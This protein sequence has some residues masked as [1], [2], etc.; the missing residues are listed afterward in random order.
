MVMEKRNIF[1]KVVSV[2][3]LLV[4]AFSLTMPVIAATS[5]TVSV[6]SSSGQKIYI[7]TGTGWTYSLGLKKTTV[8]VKNSGSYAFALYKNI[9]SNYMYVGELQPGQTKSYTAKGSGK[10][11]YVMAQKLR[12]K[13][14][15]ITVTTSAGSVYT[16]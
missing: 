2:L 15:K 10:E 9:G 7:K 8:T 11:Y 16:K 6:T 5:K 3:M 4:M 1:I 13:N 14:S 12:G